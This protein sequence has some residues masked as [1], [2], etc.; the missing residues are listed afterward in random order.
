[1]GS[2]QRYREL[3]AHLASHRAELRKPEMVGVSGASSADKTRLRCHEFE[4]GFI[5]MAT[6]LADRKLAFF[7]IL[8]GAA[9]G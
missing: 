5:A 8:A 2:P 1:M 9:S 6:R 7:S 3:I 4:M